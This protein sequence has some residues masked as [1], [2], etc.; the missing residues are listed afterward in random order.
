MS[1]DRLQ[2]LGSGC[3]AVV[4]VLGI[5]YALSPDFYSHR[6]QLLLLLLLMHYHREGS[7]GTKRLP[8]F[9]DLV[10]LT[11]ELFNSEVMFLPQNCPDSNL[12]TSIYDV[13]IPLKLNYQFFLIHDSENHM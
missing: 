13:I 2:H 7:H 8:L 9:Q 4:P 11:T 12:H 6:K 5:L 10:G 3:C 1:P